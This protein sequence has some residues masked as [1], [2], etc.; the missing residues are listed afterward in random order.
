MLH[1]KSAVKDIFCDNKTITVTMRQIR[2][3]FD[4]LKILS[5]FE[6]EWVG[7]SYVGKKGLRLLEAQYLD[8]GI[9]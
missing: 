3:S 5:L 8:T 7:D 4:L 9:A 6:N 2:G 1:I